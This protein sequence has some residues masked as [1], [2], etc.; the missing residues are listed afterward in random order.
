MKLV[1]LIPILILVIASCTKSS[2]T[3]SDIQEEAITG[4]N[5]GNQ[6][7]TTFVEDAKKYGEFAC[8]V[9]NCAGTLC[10]NTQ[11][12]CKKKACTAIPDACTKIAFSTL[13]I[14]AIATKHAKQM[15]A[16]GFIDLKDFE[17]S[18]KLAVEIL[19]AR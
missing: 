8:V 9:N 4:S 5:K 18:K 19:T 13:E 14:E 12:S 11:G 2:S 17:K 3:N 7:V 10:D 15:I 1:K 6:P 16:D